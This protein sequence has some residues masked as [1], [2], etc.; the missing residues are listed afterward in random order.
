MILKY[1]SCGSRLGDSFTI[2][3]YHFLLSNVTCIGCPELA[4]L[5]SRLT[6]RFLFRFRALFFAHFSGNMK[7][8]ANGTKTP[9]INAPS[10]VP[11]Y[12]IGALPESSFSHRPGPVRLRSD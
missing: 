1:C 9:M 11:A 2:P 12:G 6:K 10:A 7:L 3:M 8:A 4:A 5:W